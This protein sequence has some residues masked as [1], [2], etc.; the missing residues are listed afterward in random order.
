MQQEFVGTITKQA[1]RD[2]NGKT[3]YNIF[4][5]ED[6]GSEDIMIGLGMDKPPVSPQS[7]VKLTATKNQKGYWVCKAKDITLLK[8][9]PAPA[10]S[11]GGKPSG[12][13]VDRQASIVLQSSFK[14]ATDQVN[15]LL[16]AGLFKPA[17]N[18]KAKKESAMDAYFSF[19]DK[20]AVELYN[21]CMEPEKFLDDYITN[22]ADYSENPGPNED[23]GR[24]IEDDLPDF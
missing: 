6:N 22:A 10:P 5:R 16:A 14:T 17:A 20:V 23:E 24:P 4:I 18:T 9:Q 1:E 3:L 21:R 8:D 2:W 7:R 19:V 11:G 13:F 15:S 12:G